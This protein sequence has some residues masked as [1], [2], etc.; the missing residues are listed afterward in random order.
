MSAING[1]SETF[2]LLRQMFRDQMMSIPVSFSPLTGGIVN[3]VYEVKTSDGGSYVVRV[4]K[5]SYET[6]MK[7]KWVMEQVATKSVTVPS[8]YAVG[9]LDNTESYMILEKIEGISG[10]KISKESQIETYRQLGHFAKEVNSIIV[11]TAGYG[12]NFSLFPTP[13]FLEPWEEVWAWNENNV[14]QA[15]ILN[16]VLGIHAEQTQQIR[17]YLAPL[18]KLN[19]PPCL[20]HCDISLDNCIVRSDGSV[21]LIDWTL[22]HAM[23]SNVFELGN[24]ITWDDDQDHVQ[25]FFTGYGITDA[26]W[27]TIKQDVFR[28][29]LLNLLKA[30]TWCY[31]EQKLSE[32]SRIKKSVLSF[33]SMNLCLFPRNEFSPL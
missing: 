22:T 13:H 12:F 6:F 15:D 17:E 2:A 19:G 25:A 5:D 20:C 28:A 26:Q 10:N 8:V 4:Q 21:V 3:K 23:P 30:A 16:Q 32:Y 11:P 14:L 27:D 9:K 24:M 18:S 31:Q 7:E 1:D 29:K 33:L